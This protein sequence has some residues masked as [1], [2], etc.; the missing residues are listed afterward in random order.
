MGLEFAI[1]SLYFTFRSD[2]ESPPFIVNYRSAICCEQ[3]IQGD[4]EVRDALQTIMFH[5][6]SDHPLYFALLIKTIHVPRTES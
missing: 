6:F 3:R 4:S 5:G 1:D 2:L